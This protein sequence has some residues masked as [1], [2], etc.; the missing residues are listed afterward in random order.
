MNAFIESKAID[1]IEKERLSVKVKN[2]SIFKTISADDTNYHFGSSPHYD[3]LS[4]RKKFLHGG[5]VMYTNAPTRKGKLHEIGFICW[6]RKW[7]GGGG[8]LSWPL[9]DWNNPI[10]FEPFT[11]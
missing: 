8:L 10:V 5:P 4:S 3:C 9:Q 1:S 6:E 7:E 2:Y 11:R